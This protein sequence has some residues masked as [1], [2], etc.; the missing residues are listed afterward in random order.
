MPGF[1]RS[2]AQYYFVN[3][4]SAVIFVEE[5]FILSASCSSILRLVHFYGAG[6]NS[7]QYVQHQRFYVGYTSSAHENISGWTAELTV[8]WIWLSMYVVGV[9]LLPP[10]AIDQP[11]Q[12]FGPLPDSLQNLIGAYAV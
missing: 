5:T 7:S 8:E 10:L 3:L 4:Y 11:C 9:F 12:S 6:R 1:L 2:V